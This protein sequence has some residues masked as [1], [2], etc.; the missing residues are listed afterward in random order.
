MKE[1]IIINKVEVV[2]EGNGVF[3]APV[4]FGKTMFFPYEDLS[5]L[6]EAFKEL[7]EKSEIPAED[8]PEKFYNSYGDEIYYTGKFEVPKVGEWYLNL[9]PYQVHLCDDD[10]TTK[11]AIYSTTKTTTI[12]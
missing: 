6:I 10:L 12:I 4:G 7:L 11:H 8:F 1:P 5:K 2:A 3:L 9:K